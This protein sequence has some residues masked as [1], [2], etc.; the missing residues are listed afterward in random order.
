MSEAAEDEVTAMKAL[1]LT[2]T[3]TA[4]ATGAV[5]Q[6]R[7]STLTMSCAQA[8]SVVASRGAVVLSTG[9]HTY[10]RYVSRRKFCEIN[11][12]VQPVWV[13]TAD[14]RQCLIGYRCIDTDLEFFDD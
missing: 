10:D 7:P 8:G 4:L 12:T 11:E 1:A 14:A 5:A 2:L 13:P 9:Q 3:L 6:S